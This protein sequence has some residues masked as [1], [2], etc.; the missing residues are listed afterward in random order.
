MW[1]QECKVSSTTTSIYSILTFL[2]MPGSFIMTPKTASAI[3]RPQVEVAATLLLPSENNI[4]LM[5]SL[6]YI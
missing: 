6:I 3:I 1:D 2:A 5:A 4:L